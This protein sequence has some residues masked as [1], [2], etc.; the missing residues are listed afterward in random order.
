MNQQTLSE[1]KKENLV[2]GIYV[3]LIFVLIAVIYAI[4]NVTTL[5]NTLISF[6][7]SF[8]MAQVPGTS[9]SLPAPI[10]PAAFS[11]I[12][13]VAFEFCLGIGLL[14]VLVLSL[15]IMI[16]SPIPRKAETIENIVFWLGTSY[17]TLTYLGNMAANQ[18]SDW[19]VF[20]AGIILIAG[21]SLVARAFV[22]IARH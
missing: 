22:L 15:R 3:G 16:H 21:L 13:N 10:N 18:P 17:L 2:T 9:I 12:Y 5:G 19:F 11:A 7:N 20:W 4:N 1:K 14:E 8:F 6:F